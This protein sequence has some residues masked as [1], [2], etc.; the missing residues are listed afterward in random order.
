MDRQHS[1]TVATFFRHFR[2]FYPSL[3]VCPVSTG[4]LSLIIRCL[5][6]I[7]YLGKQTQ[8]QYCLSGTLSL[9]VFPMYVSIN[10]LPTIYI[11]GSENLFSVSEQ[12][13]TF[14]ERQ[15]EVS[16]T[17]LCSRVSKVSYSKDS[18]G[19]SSPSCPPILYEVPWRLKGIIRY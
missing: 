7:P 2:V 9:V 3:L 6:M 4:T 14:Q 16:A 1:A 5:V 18:S 10:A 13:V 12:E 11:N 17:H 19:S 15:G 8:Y